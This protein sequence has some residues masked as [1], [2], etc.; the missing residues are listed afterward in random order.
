M[1]VETTAGARIS[2]EVTAYPR[3]KIALYEYGSG[4][5]LRIGEFFGSN[6]YVRLGFDAESRRDACDRL[7]AV[8]TAAREY[9]PTEPD[10]AETEPEAVPA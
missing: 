9:V 1:T 6:V 5:G 3:T 8:L 7:I 2:V 10:A 4:C